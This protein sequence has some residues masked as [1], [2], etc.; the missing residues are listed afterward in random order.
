MVLRGELTGIPDISQLG[1]S[2]P[3]AMPRVTLDDLSNG[4]DEFSQ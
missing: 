4:W 3:S 1:A 2:I